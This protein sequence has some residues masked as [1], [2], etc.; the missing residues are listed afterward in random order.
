[1]ELYEELAKIKKDYEKCC[2][3]KVQ[4]CD[5]IL[6]KLGAENKNISIF[7]ETEKLRNSIIKTYINL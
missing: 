5:K 4:E 6:R 2:K 3:A 7:R 1:M